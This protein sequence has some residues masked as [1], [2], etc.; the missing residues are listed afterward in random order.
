[1][2]QTTGTKTR[3]YWLLWVF[4]V[5]M[6]HCSKS[7]W[8]VSFVAHVE[9]I[10]DTQH[11]LHFCSINYMYLGSPMLL[12]TGLY[13]FSQIRRH[14]YFYR[15]NCPEKTTSLYVPQRCFSSTIRRTAL[16]VQSPV[17]SRHVLLHCTSLLLLRWKCGYRKC[18]TRRMCR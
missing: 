8:H 1:M 2:Q 16:W 4:E 12:I 13:F 18:G 11:G 9:L 6:L 3:L 14:S 17:F 5:V 15:Q 7:K 10:T